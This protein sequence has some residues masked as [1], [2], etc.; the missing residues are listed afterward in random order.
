M[1]TENEGLLAEHPCEWCAP[2][3]VTLDDN[4]HRQGTCEQKRIPWLF[5]HGDKVLPM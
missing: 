1:G 3:E 5:A 4:S 2:S